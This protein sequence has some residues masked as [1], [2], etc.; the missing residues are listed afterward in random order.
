MLKNDFIIIKCHHTE[1][2]YHNTI[3]RL[4]DR[5]SVQWFNKKAEIE[6]TFSLI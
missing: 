5:K 4:H 1:I 3:W 2:S 6:V